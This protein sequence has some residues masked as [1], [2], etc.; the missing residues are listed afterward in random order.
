MP[1]VKATSL[2][3]GCS[4]PRHNTR[5]PLLHHT[6]AKHCC[7]HTCPRHSQIC[8]AAT[9]DPVKG[10]SAPLSAE[11]THRC[12]PSWG[13]HPGQQHTKSKRKRNP[14]PQHI[15]DATTHT[16]VSPFLQPTSQWSSS[17]ARQ[18]GTAS[19][20][21]LHRSLNSFISCTHSTP[22]T[23]PYLLLCT[24]RF[25]HRYTHVPAPTQTAQPTPVFTHTRFLNPVDSTLAAPAALTD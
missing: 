6:K 8:T 15:S 18:G 3:S 23:Q 11:K 7:P 14:N 19:S 13:S 1:R 10:C 25:A 22:L 12:G 2:S 16:S 9:R 4:S 20:P 17:T 21:F 5:V 24:L